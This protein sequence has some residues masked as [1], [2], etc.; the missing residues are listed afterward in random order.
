MQTIPRNCKVLDH[1]QFCDV[2]GT[3]W[4]SGRLRLGPDGLYRCPQHKGRSRFEI[5]Q[6][7]ARVMTEIDR[8]E[9]K[10]RE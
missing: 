8:N 1:T 3:L 6:E 10:A 4:L 2:C 7:N 9:P 5:D